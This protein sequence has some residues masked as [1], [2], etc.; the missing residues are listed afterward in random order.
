MT[1]WEKGLSDIQ[2]N[3]RIEQGL[4]NKPVESS[5]KSNARIVKENVFTYFNFVFLVIAILLVIA[6]SYRNL[7][8]LPI[9]IANTLIGIAQQIRA[10]NVLTKMNMLNAPYAHVIRN[11]CKTKVPAEDLVKDDIVVFRSGEQICADAVVVNGNLRVNEALLTGESDEIEKEVGDFL[12]SGSI[13]TSGECHARLTNVGADSYISKLTLEAKKINNKEQSEMIASINKL[14]LFVGIAIIPIGIALFVQGYVINRLGFSESIVAMIAAIIGMIPE[15]L[16]LLTTV[17]MAVSAIRLAENKVLL[18]DMKSIETLARVNVLCVDKT[19]TITKNE[20]EV[21]G[22]KN[23]SSELSNEELHGLLGDFVL[24]LDADNI[25][26]KALKEYFDK[27]TGRVCKNKFGF[28]STYKYSACEFEDANYILGAPEFVLRDDYENY[29]EYVEKHSENGERVVVLAKYDGVLTGKALDS[30]A[31]AIAFVTLTNLIRDNARQTFEYFRDEGVSIKVIS[32]DNPITVSK[33]A[34]QAG[35]EGAK[36]FIDASKITEDSELIDALNKYTVFGRV[37]PEMKRRMVNL[38]KEM[39]NT[40]AMTGD[41]VNDVLALKDADC[42]VAMSSGSEAACQVSQVVLLDNDFSKMPKVVLEGR[43][44]VNNI[45]RSAGLFFV[46]NIFSFLLSLLSLIFVFKYPLEP[47]QVSFI[48]M[49]T[50]GIPGFFLALEP[51]KSR[52]EGKFLPNVLRKAIPGGV[53]DVFAVGALVFCGNAFN[54]ESSDISTAATLLLSMVGFMVLIKVCTPLNK[55]RT[56]I[57]AGN[58]VG[59]ILAGIFLN[60][61]FA[62]EAMSTECILLF[63]MFSFA[64]E[65][66]LRLIGKVVERIFPLPQYVK[67]PA[68]KLSAKS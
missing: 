47:S 29:R 18:H 33:I 28:S 20:M 38:L 10:K 32:G 61:L 17:A 9:I 2:V 8:F 40:V 15:G 68:M 41:G 44:V 51:E 3:E 63:V 7:T 50:I 58:F 16:Y 57:I 67:I 43:R 12:M 31:N 1:E 14:V 66:F 24:A 39:G 65:S 48:T 6:G 25:T 22:V 60:R 52:I 11:S 23:V 21:S 56:T 49:F 46:K 30:K 36:D 53:A 27:N 45:Q 13:V 62:L 34:M 35:I 37:T 64:A 4:T 19:G 59:L 55:L 26:M 5:E 42:S 54:L